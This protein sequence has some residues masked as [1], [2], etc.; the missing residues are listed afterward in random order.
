[1]LMCLVIMKSLK[2]PF[3]IV[4]VISLIFLSS[5]LKI[6]IL[7][8]FFCLLMV[9]GNSGVAISSPLKNPDACERAVTKQNKNQA[10]HS[11]QQI[12]RNLK[13]SSTQVRQPHD[14]TMF[15]IEDLSVGSE[16]LEQA[17][18]I[19][20]DTKAL[21]WDFYLQRQTQ[22]EYLKSHLPDSVLSQITS[23]MWLDFYHG[24]NTKDIE[25]KLLP[26]LNRISSIEYPLIQPTR[27]RAI[28]RFNLHFEGEGWKAQQ[29]K[30]NSFEQ[31]DALSIGHQQDFRIEEE[32]DFKELKLGDLS[33]TLI[34]ILQG[35]ASLIHTYDSEILNLE[36]SVHFMK[37]IK[38]P[39]SFQVVTNSPEGVHQ[40]G[41]DFVV[42]ALVIER[43][44]IQGGKNLIYDARGVLLR[45]DGNPN[46]KEH[47]SS[48]EIVLLPGHGLLH[49]D[50][51]SP[52]WHKVTPIELQD[53]S[54]EGHRSIIGIDF[55][56]K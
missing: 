30:V 29:V 37:V 25:D 54:I 31:N 39:W 48:K 47:I 45:E 21:E 14:I 51:G 4:R 5:L 18:E 23:I 9:L 50:R 6:R 20:A 55:Q 10:V 19:F 42:P 11:S 24:R 8:S 15:S 17:G 49:R 22:I 2:Y 26:H 32:R 33:E 12:N 1:M 36:A 28:S 7:Q 43:E 13:P 35:L 16:F 56:I 3:L 40:D 52:L 34:R 27:L 46:F 53:H 44:N 41:K 38:R